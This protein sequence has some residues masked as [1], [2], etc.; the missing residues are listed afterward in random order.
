MK[1]NMTFITSCTNNNFFTR[2]FK[3]GK[4]FS[5]NFRESIFHLLCNFSTLGYCSANIEP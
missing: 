3:I 5:K 4:K 2:N 1:K